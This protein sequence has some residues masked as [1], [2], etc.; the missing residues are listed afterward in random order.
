MTLLIRIC[1]GAG[2]PF[3]VV[4]GDH[5]ATA[6]AIAAQAGIISNPTAVHYALDLL[7]PPATP[8]KANEDKK[9]N[10][11]IVTHDQG[12]NVPL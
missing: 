3:F 11:V 6:I 4:T 9:E 8:G 1:H 7:D 5:P 2:I 12:D 10:R